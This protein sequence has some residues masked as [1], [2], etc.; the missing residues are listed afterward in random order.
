MNINKLVRR[1]LYFK[2]LGFKEVKMYNDGY[3]T[4]KFAL[5]IEQIT[6]VNTL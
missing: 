6:K 2:S 5:S 3:Y 1:L 4:E